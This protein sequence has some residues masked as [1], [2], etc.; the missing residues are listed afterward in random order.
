MGELELRLVALNREL[1]RQ[2]SDAGQANLDVL[3]KAEESL[4]EVK[5]DNS[6][7]NIQLKEIEKRR[8]EEEEDHVAEVEGYEEA[9]REKNEAIR[10]LSEKVKTLEGKQASPTVS[11]MLRANANIPISG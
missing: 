7:L 8:K 10:D 1:Q 5:A 11:G 2:K 4:M 9:I 3:S 6:S